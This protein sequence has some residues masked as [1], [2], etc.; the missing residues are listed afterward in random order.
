M[1][2][3]T[4]LFYGTANNLTYITNNTTL[5]VLRTLF[6]FWKEKFDWAEGQSWVVTIDVE[7][8]TTCSN[9]LC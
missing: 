4:L 7:F 8:S 3:L 1:E 2:D 5:E 9:F 6:S